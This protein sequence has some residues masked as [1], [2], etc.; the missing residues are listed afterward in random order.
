[1]ILITTKTR[2]NLNGN[3]ISYT[4]YRTNY[5]NDEMMKENGGMPN[6]SSGSDAPNKLF[7]WYS[8][9]L[10]YT[11]IENPSVG[12]KAFS[13]SD[14]G[15]VTYEITDVGDGYITIYDEQQQRNPSGDI[16]LN[17]E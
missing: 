17:T 14:E 16:D 4:T 11:A 10:Y 6:A 9:G 2:K 5:S 15:I 1:M 3:S 13:S 7:S 12:D 8:S